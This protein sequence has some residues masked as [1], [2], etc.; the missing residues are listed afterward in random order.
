MIPLQLR[1]LRFIKVAQRDKRAV[2]PEW[3]RRGGANYGAD[4]EELREWIERGGNYGVCCGVEVDG[5]QLI[6]IDADEGAVVELVQNPFSGLPRT[7]TVRTGSGGTH[8]YYF[9]ED[10]A[11]TACALKREG[12]HVGDI[13]AKSTDGNYTQVV[14][15]GSVHPS[16]GRYE[17]IDAT[18]IARITREDLERCLGPLLKESAMSDAAAAAVDELTELGKPADFSEFPLRVT[19]IVPPERY[20]LK[21][22]GEEWYGA[23]PVHGSERTG[24]NFWMHERQNSWFCFRCGAGGGPI[25]LIA[26]VEGIVPCEFFRIEKRIVAEKGKERTVRVYKPWISTLDEEKRRLL[27]EALKKYGVDMNEAKTSIRLVVDGEECGWLH[28]ERVSG[29]FRVSLSSQEAILTPPTEVKANWCYTTERDRILKPLK[30][31]LDS[32][33]YAKLV[34]IIQR[35]FDRI[36]AEETKKEPSVEGEVSYDEDLL[37]RVKRHLDVLHTGDDDVKLLTFVLSASSLMENFEEVAPFVLVKGHSSA[38]KSH[39][40]DAATRWV[41]DFCLDAFPT[42]A[43]LKYVDWGA[44]KVIKLRELFGEEHSK[45]RLMSTSDGGFKLMVSVKKDNTWEAQEFEI[46]PR[47]IFSTTVKPEVDEQFENRS[48]ILEVDESAEQTRRV[49]HFVAESEIRKAHSLLAG[50]TSEDWLRKLAGTLRPYRVV[51]PYANYLPQ[52]F[53]Q[54]PMRISFR[55][56]I[57]KLIQLVKLVAFVMQKRRPKVGDIILATPLDL[58]YAL[59]IAWRSLR[60]TLSRMEER[61]LRIL[62]IVKEIIPERKVS[63]VKRLVAESGISKKYAYQLIKS[64]EDEGLMKYDNSDKVYV[65]TEEGEEFLRVCSL[66]MPEIDVNKLREVVLDNFETLPEDVECVIEESLKYVKGVDPFTGEDV[67]LLCSGGVN[68]TSPEDGGEGSSGG[69]DENPILISKT[70]PIRLGLRDERSNERASNPVCNHVLG[71]FRH[72]S[73]TESGDPHVGNTNCGED[74][75]KGDTDTPE[76]ATTH[77]ECNTNL[78]K[79]ITRTGDVHTN[80]AKSNTVHTKSEKRNTEHRELHTNLE[81][82]NTE[83][84]KCSLCCNLFPKDE[85]C[86]TPHG[87]L[88]REC[89]DI[90]ED[91]IRC[92][93]CGQKFPKGDEALLREHQAR[94]EAFRKKVEGDAIFKCVC[95]FRTNNHKELMEHFDESKECYE[96]ILRGI[97]PP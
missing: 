81:K 36:S 91:G 92:F 88:C 57:G 44:I 42:E 15:P 82:S 18:E 54:L 7:F 4:D 77:S 51:V 16:G 3:N 49:V 72:V 23:H 62:E 76:S 83:V 25:S 13:R 53:E 41:S 89:R 9:L 31:R 78:E 11:F 68:Q 19:D 45:L 6:V 40:L 93:G 90:F 70:T 61:K 33:K 2:E 66:E 79:S 43:S 64:V 80:L 28:V 85:L 65:V 5:A 35:A 55:R 67:T 59:R 27:F 14:G 46:P 69:D 94:C 37:Y 96:K 17:V 75:T 29:R 8:F 97:P 58:Y 56:D 73:D 26:V 71:V 60:V 84:E 86:E 47:P 30:E 63:I 74:I 87:R 22:S 10:E 21:R 38:G 95:G 48:W 20:G 52:L 34:R 39:L 50:E 12:R 1:G 32:V 24:R